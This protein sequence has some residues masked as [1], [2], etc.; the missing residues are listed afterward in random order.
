MNFAKVP[1][2]TTAQDIAATCGVSERTARRWIARGQM[3]RA[4]LTAYRIIRF[5]DLGAIDATWRGW[6]L[7][8]GQLHNL[9][10]W[11]FRPGEVNSLPLKEQLIGELHRQLSRPK[12]WKLL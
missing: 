9:D 3:P 1:Q 8:R 6:R 4:M 12:Q 7:V 11:S 5:G 10:G 2:D